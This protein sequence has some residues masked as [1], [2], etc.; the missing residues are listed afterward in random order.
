M[1][2]VET[3]SIVFFG[4]K[5]GGSQLFT[6]EGG[7]FESIIHV[8]H[9]HRP[10]HQPVILLDRPHRLIQPFLI[11]KISHFLTQT[12]PRANLLVLCEDCVFLRFSS[13]SSSCHVD[14]P[15]LSVS[16][17]I[18]LQNSCSIAP[19]HPAST[20]RGW[21]CFTLC[22]DYIV[23]EPLTSSIQKDIKLM[24]NELILVQNPLPRNRND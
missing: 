2:G 1:E 24:K 5:E 21:E 10:Q 14:L 18:I 11:S 8:A 4:G 20:N 17:R 23:S 19:N 3:E 6:N 12:P 22:V 13:S 9:V 16:C 7:V 15:T